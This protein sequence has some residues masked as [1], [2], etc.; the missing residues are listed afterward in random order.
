MNRYPLNLLYLLL[1]LCISVVALPPDALA[2]RPRA[3]RAARPAL[4]VK[5]NAVLRRTHVVIRRAYVAVKTGN[6]RT[7]HLARAIRHQRF[8]VRLHRQ[9]FFARAIHHSRLAR[10]LAITALRNN[11]VSTPDV[12]NL[13]DIPAEAGNMP[14]EAQLESDLKREFPDAGP[15]TDDAVLS[16]SEPT[17]TDLGADE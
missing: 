2:Q 14:A 4:R 16:R 7:G 9:A 8:A 5:S 15:E 1:G 6:S 3:V 17:D 12:D 10:T 11:K 13:N